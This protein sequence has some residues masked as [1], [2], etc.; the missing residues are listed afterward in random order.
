MIKLNRIGYKLGLAGVLS[1][2]LAAG[3]V[4]NQMIAE[5]H[6]AGSTERAGRSQRVADSSLAAHLDLRKMQLTAR[7]V[8]LARTAVDVEKV[9]ADLQ[10]FKASE[11]KQLE[12]AQATAMKPETKERIAQIKSLMESF[13]AAVEDLAKA[14][15][16]LLAQIDKRSAISSEWSKAIEAE[17]AS[18]ALAKLDNRLEIEKLLYQADAKVNSLRAMVWRLGATGDKSQI[19]QIAKT[20][21]ALKTNFNLLRGEADDRELLTVI[22]SLDQIVK[23]F[24]AAN[25]E[26][27]KSEELKADIVENRTIKVVADAADLMEATVENAQKNSTNSKQEVVAATAQANEVNLI[28]AI[29]V[30]LSLI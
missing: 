29:V 12:I 28:M 15:T 3:M 14:Q 23:R 5:T 7:E 2:V 21:T 6:V 17:L 22:S 9:V 25:D 13:A 11:I 8:R 27:V 26:V 19:A 24:L 10:R 4:A 20:Q 30:I 18:P 1:V 16:T